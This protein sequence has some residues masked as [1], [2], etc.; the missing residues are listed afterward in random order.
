MKPHQPPK[1]WAIIPAAGSGSRFSSHELKQYQRIQSKTVLEHT[2]NQINLLDLA[3]CVLV[4]SEQ[5]TFARTLTFDHP[6][7]IH[8]CTGGKE[9]VDSVRNGL[10][11]LL[12]IASEDDWVMVHDAARPCVHLSS[13][14]CLS[15]T[16]IAQ[17]KSAILAT[18]VRDTLKKSFAN[19]N[20]IEKTVNRDQLWQAQTP[21]ISKIGLL[22]YAIDHA[23]SLDNIAITDEASALEVIHETVLMIPGRADNIKITYPDDLILAK[24]ILASQHE[25]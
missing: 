22:K 17:N 19:Q 7:K 11:Y 18:P 10:D 4:V 13:L 12:S 20:Y 9:R 2:V 3:G 23:L 5:D 16:A 15:T 21:Q 8:F 6:E 14:Q 24:F 1:L 25:Q